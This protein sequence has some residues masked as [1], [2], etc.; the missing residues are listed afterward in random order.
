MSIF[1]QKNSWAKLSP[2]LWAFSE[3]CWFFPLLCYHA[4]LREILTGPE[5]CRTVFLKGMACHRVLASS[6]P[7]PLGYQ[8]PLKLFSSLPK[9]ARPLI[10]EA[11]TSWAS[12]RLS[13]SMSVITPPLIHN[14]LLLP[15]QGVVDWFQA[16]WLRPG[17][18]SNL[19]L[20][21]SLWAKY[22]AAEL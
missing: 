3:H 18:Q 14:C 5:L 22:L 19:F 12:C 8:C 9:K 7:L 16:P 4:R 20:V 2:V 10:F 13:F 21:N 15:W 11:F 6:W 1:Y 17:F